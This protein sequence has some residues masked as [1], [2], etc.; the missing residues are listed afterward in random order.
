MN[1]TFWDQEYAKTKLL[2]PIDQ[3]DQ[4]CTPQTCSVLLKR[5]NVSLW[6]RVHLTFKHFI[7]ARFRVKTDLIR[8]IQDRVGLELSVFQ[9]THKLLNTSFIDDFVKTGFK[10]AI[11]QPRKVVR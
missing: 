5:L 3:F 10:M 8:N 1:S 4:T 7:K 11:E 6:C 9:S 2:I